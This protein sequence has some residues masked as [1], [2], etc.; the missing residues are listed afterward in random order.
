M[1]TSFHCAL[2]LR[3]EVNRPDVRN[4]LASCLGVLR[5]HGL[6]PQ[7]YAEE[8]WRTGGGLILGGFSLRHPEFAASTGD[9]SWGAG[10]MVIPARSAAATLL[11]LEVPAEKE[12][13]RSWRWLLP[14]AEELSVAIAAD[15]ALINGFVADEH[16]PR[17]GTPSGPELSPGHPA[18]VLCPWMYWSPRRLVE[19]GLATDRLARLPA[20]RSSATPGGGWVLQPRHDY[21]GAPP[22]RLLKAWA[23]AWD[24]R[25]PF[26]AG[27]R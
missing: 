5:A 10:F 6:E 13:S 26:W 17:G 25:E 20:A 14:L 21:S 18:G 27:I 1:L 3:G 16:A 12:A 7:P 19:D 15:L 22:K 4:R 9:P 8:A 23:S 11:M 2:H 24:V